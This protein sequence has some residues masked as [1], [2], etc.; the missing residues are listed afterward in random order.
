MVKSENDFTYF[1]IDIDVDQS[2]ADINN[3][4][5]SIYHKWR[6][7]HQIKETC[8]YDQV[9]QCILQ[10]MI[11]KA[12][13]LQQLS[14]GFLVNHVRI[15]DVSSM[16]S[17]LR[18]IYEMAL[19]Y[20]NIFIQTENIIE[21]RILFLLWQIRGYNNLLHLPDIPSEFLDN[22]D[23]IKKTN[24]NLRNSIITLIENLNITEKAKGEIVNAIDK[25]STKISAYYF[26][27]DNHNTIFNFQ[28]VSIDKS[29]S[30]F[31]DERYA[32]L[33]NYLSIHSHP[34]YLGLLEF[35]KM[36]DDKKVYSH[37]KCL[38]LMACICLSKFTYD[39]CDV[40]DGGKTIWT[41]YETNMTTIN[42]FSQL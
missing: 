26:P 6:D 2:L 30:L 14:D 28:R 22:K 15:I 34:S 32:N 35:G 33:Y 10:M 19:I 5:F 17:I 37:R 29:K 12:K 39:F 21:R 7:S 1:Q 27:K 8:E 18:G 13:S 20:H 11:S 3:S 41:D 40:V 24:E 23:E 31:N 16:A 9:S 36:F 38:L 25:G 42:F 4:M